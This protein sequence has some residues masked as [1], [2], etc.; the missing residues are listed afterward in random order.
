MYSTIQHVNLVSDAVEARAYQLDAVN[1]SLA[2]SMLLILPTAAGK[3]AVAWMLIA[4]K[5]IEEEGKI[6]LIAPTVALVNQHLK[7]INKTLT[8]KKLS[9]YQ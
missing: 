8:L 3:T 9:L 5:L 2:G 1:E 7:G 4:E 6:L